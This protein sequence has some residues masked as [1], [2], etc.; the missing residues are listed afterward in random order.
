[1]SSGSSAN[2]L[3]DELGLEP[4][5]DLQALQTAVLRQDPALGWTAEDTAEGTAL[6]AS[7]AGR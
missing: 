3:D 4:G 5:P 1:M 6:G 7:S 2:V